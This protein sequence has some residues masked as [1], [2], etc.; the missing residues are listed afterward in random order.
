MV[1]GYLIA[2]HDSYPVSWVLV[3]VCCVLVLYCIVLFCFLQLY[4]QFNTQVGALTE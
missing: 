2:F 1:S 3:V 4:F